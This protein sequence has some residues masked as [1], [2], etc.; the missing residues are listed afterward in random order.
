MSSL[1]KQ[2]ETQCEETVSYNNFIKGLNKAKTLVQSSFMHHCRAKSFNE[3]ISQN[4]QDTQKISKNK[5]ISLDLDNVGEEG[6]AQ[7]IRSPI[8]K[9]GK[10]SQSIL[11]L[12]GNSKGR[13]T[14]TVKSESK[15][16]DTFTEIYKKLDKLKETDK[17]ITEI[18]TKFEHTKLENHSLK[19]EILILKSQIKNFQRIIVEMTKKTDF[20][21]KE[22]DRLEDTITELIIDNRELIKENEKL[23][24][25]M[26]NWEN[27][28]SIPSNKL[29]LQDDLEQKILS[30]DREKDEKSEQYQQLITKFVSYLQEFCT[31]EEWV[32]NLA[33]SK[34]PKQEILE[35]EEIINDRIV[36]IK[37]EINYCQ[38]LI[39]AEK[40]IEKSYFTSMSSSMIPS[41]IN[42]PN[43]TMRLTIFND[44]HSPSSK[45]N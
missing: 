36:R 17:E 14:D 15:R 39:Y 4:L 27:D 37:S 40:L 3:S 20:I 2:P 44:F 22:R 26:G 38:S 19:Q 5:N 33:N 41:P 34:L 16:F 35:C 18:K 21:Q 32:L 6:T 24:S 12:I 28:K 45:D 10:S 42:S 31:S 8:F 11:K 7:H 13:D 1:K 43:R 25:L 23:T 29:Y 9:R 30:L